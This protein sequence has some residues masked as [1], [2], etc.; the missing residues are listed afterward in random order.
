MGIQSEGIERFRELFPALRE[1]VASAAYE[2]F[3]E[4][5][6]LAIEIGDHSRLSLY[7]PTLTSETDGGSLNPGAVDPRTF[8]TIG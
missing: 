6:R 8:T 2:C 4:Y 5:A 1:P 3:R 7:P